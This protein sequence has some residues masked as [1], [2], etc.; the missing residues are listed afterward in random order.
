M[1]VA[2]RGVATSR[3]SAGG[4]RAL[5]VGAFVAALA[6]EPASAWQL[7]SRSLAER[8]DD[9]PVI[10]VARVAATY[11]REASP[12]AGVGDVWEARLAIIRMLKG[13]LPDG[14]RVTFVDVA[15]ED[16][17]SFKPDEARVW[18]LKPASAPATY[19]ASAGYESVLRA[20]L[21][22]QVKALITA[23]RRRP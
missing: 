15:V 1:S 20:A 17:P 14:A 23:S 18:L 11:S 3:R 7:E 8:V 22:P 9:A 6:C 21:E 4:A 19:G 10:V 13:S 16:R 5:V 2:S 12:I